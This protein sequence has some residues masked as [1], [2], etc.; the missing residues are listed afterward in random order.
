[1][2][3]IDNSAVLTEPQAL[4][5][6]QNAEDIAQAL[7]RWSQLPKATSIEP[8]YTVVAANPSFDATALDGSDLANL[9]S[10]PR[11]KDANAAIVNPHDGLVR[12]SEPDRPVRIRRGGQ[13]NAFGPSH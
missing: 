6:L 13:C 3:D 2:R 4:I 5:R 10:L 11:G 8:G 7:S 1:M 9:D 12:Q